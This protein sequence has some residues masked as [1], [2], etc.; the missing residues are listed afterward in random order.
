MATHEKDV[1]VSGDSSDQERIDHE[2][3]SVNAKEKQQ[4]IDQLDSANA[5]AVFQNPLRG[6]SKSALM[7]NVEK[8]CADFDLMDDVEDF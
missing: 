3:G 6:L 8:F 4:T 5:S 1:A 2:D 7:I